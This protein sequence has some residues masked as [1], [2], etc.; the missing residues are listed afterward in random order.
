MNKIGVI[1]SF[2]CFSAFCL[3][4]QTTKKDT[5]IKRDLIMEKEYRPEIDSKEKI[6]VLPEIESFT[7][8]K[9]DPDYFLSGKPAYL[10]G[11]YLPLPAPGVK[12]EFPS[13]NQL[14]YLR[15][16]A[17][18]KFS[19]V[20]DGQINFLRS[21]KHTL[22]VRFMH[23]SI[24]GEMTNTMGIKDRAY[25]NK[26]RIMANYKL[27]LPENELTVSLSEKYNSWNYYGTWQNSFTPIDTTINY[28]EISGNQWSSDIKYALGFNSRKPGNV[29]TWNA[30]VEGHIF[31][32]GRGIQ[33]LSMPADANKG[34]KEKE[35]KAYANLALDIAEK[36]ELGVKGNIRK[37]S[38]RTPVSYSLDMLYRADPTIYD[39][40][41]TSQSW[42]DLNPYAKIKL[43]R[44][45]VTGGLR[46]S[47]P[48]LE[49]ERVRY[50]VTA[51]AMAPINDRL[52]FK[53]NL[54]GG[55]QMLSYREGFEMNPYLDPL[56]HL[57]PLRKP[58]D[59]LVGID[60]RPVKSLR[61]SPVI[62]YERFENMHFFYND[63]PL[64]EFIKKAYGKIFSAKYM[65]SNKF[66]GGVNIMYN[67]LNKISLFGEA[68]YNHYINY[69]KDAATDILLDLNGRKA[70][71]KPGL[72]MRFRLEFSPVDMVS[73]FA[74]YQLS[75]LRYAPTSTAFSSR[76]G[77]IHD[78]NIGLS[79][80]VTKD[81]DVFLHIDNVLDQRYELWNSYRSHGMS[82]MIGGSVHF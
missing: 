30:G 60:Y 13:Q 48:S 38:Y 7:L 9:R 41:Y 1:I 23:K 31:R 15:I 77:D 69:S 52:S 27:N 42:V 37:F 28:P 34:G 81:V 2:F 65:K 35:I 4:A 10:K 45:E 43:K 22:D 80:K 3:Q 66:S 25:M 20:G 57:E 24:F 53:A 6:L 54:D 8:G 49:T 47:V 5:T 68:R 64:D 70:W 46:V 21:S 36:F 18:S 63:Y 32:L 62:S 14:G 79:W 58:V 71:H 50:S 76:M 44:W 40:Y 29:F 17:G 59:L 26:N 12:T 73:V 56:I 74:D 67:Y 78:L 72:E 55:I 82:A 75:A 19:F 61:I 51:S 16:G 11:E 33:H 39:N